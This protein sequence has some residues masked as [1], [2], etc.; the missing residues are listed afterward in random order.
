MKNHEINCGSAVTFNKTCSFTFLS[1]T[2][3]SRA[4]FSVGQSRRGAL[5]GEE[6]RG[7]ARFG[8]RTQLTNTRNGIINPKM[9]TK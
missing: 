4:V 1:A 2:S 8:C 6:N 7:H 9:S 5:A 3:T